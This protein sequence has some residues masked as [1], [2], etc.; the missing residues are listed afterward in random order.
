VNRRRVVDD[1]PDG[2]R[3]MVERRSHKSYGEA[4]MCCQKT[5]LH[6]NEEEKH[7]RR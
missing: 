2:Y 7:I 3:A 1:V 6:R 5:T 4:L